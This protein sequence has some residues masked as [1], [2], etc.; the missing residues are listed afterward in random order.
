[1]VRRGSADEA[2]SF[3]RSHQSIF[4]HGGVAVPQTLIK[5][6]VKRAPEL[7]NVE[8]MHLHTNGD[9]SYAHP[10][11]RGHFKVCNFFVGPNIRPYIDFERVDYLP[12][13]LSEIP[14]L[15]RSGRKK[16]DVALLHVSTPDEHGYCSL[17]T[18]VDVARAALETAKLVIA[19]VNPRMP[20][21]FGDGVIPFD[22]IHFAVEVDEALPEVP[23]KALTEV[24]KA[25]GRN[26]AAL[27]E[28]GA[29]L[30][31]GIG[32]IPDAVLS[33]LEG[34]RNLGL[35]TEMWSD[36]AIPLLEKGVI[37]NSQKT[38]HPGRS[39]S[40]FV[41]GTKKLY[42]FIN[43]NPSVLQLE[44]AYVNNP[45]VI[46]RN[47]RVTA[48]NSAVEIDLTGQV[49]ADSVGRHIISGVGGQI[50]FIRGASLSQQGKPI[51]AL[52]SRTHKGVPRVVTMLK[53]GAG[54]VTT[55]A[56]VHFVVTEH[57]VAEL[58]GKTLNERAKALIAIAH[59]EDREALEN[60]WK[61]F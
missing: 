43:N 50:D 52:T 21:V 47:K 24:E 20:R 12:C 3:I 19:Q 39:V 1:M 61:N 23:V 36:G 26:V 9:V 33:A 44:S 45:S 60:G 57:G 46:C 17:G 35:H 51:I 10:Q 25:I 49:C 8:I 41:T 48:I 55:R 15:F 5:S 42:D 38:V 59:P 18:S 34:H 40:S 58:F 31:L 30:Q 2:V 22:K 28:E 7:E 56:H 32:S 53:E 29:T 13:F 4:I 11:Y 6:L 37:N 54:V 16:I 14:S 27:V